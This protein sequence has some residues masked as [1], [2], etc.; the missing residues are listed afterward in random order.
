M[1]LVNNVLMLLL[2]VYFSV[3]ECA[4]ILT[5]IP[6]P[7]F[8]H[9]IATQPIW[10]EL[11]LRG[12]QVTSLTTDPVN[13][14]QL[15]NLTEI[16]IKFSNN[17][18]KLMY[19]NHFQTYIDLYDILAISCDAQLERPLIQDLIKSENES[20]DLVI[21]ETT[22]P[23][24]FAFAHKFNCPSIG[25]TTL[26][27]TPAIYSVLGNP[28]HPILYPDYWL[29]YSKD[30]SI[31]DRIFSV[32][33]YVFIMIH[34]KF[35]LMP[36]YQGIMERH[37]G[38]DY[39]PLQQL[40]ANMSVQLVNTD[41]IFRQIRPMTPGIIPIGGGLHRLPPEPLSNDL[42]R[43]LDN[44]NKGFIYFSLGSNVKSEF[45]H[46]ERRNE[47]LAAFAELPYTVI[48]KYGNNS[49]PN[50]PKNVLI[51]QW[52]PQISV[53]NHPNIKLF[54]THGGLQSVTEAIY[55]HVPMIGIPFFVD[56]FKNVQEMVDD[57]YG[58]H[59]GRE[60]LEKGYMQR[61]ILEAINN[62]K[63]RIKLKELTKLA[64]DQPMT[65]L[66]RAVWWIEYVLR[67]EGEIHLRSPTIDIPFYQHYFLDVIALLLVVFLGLLKVSLTILKLTLKFIF[68]SKRPK[69]FH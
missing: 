62:P 69:V 45:L 34:D 13:D 50:K 44:A 28:T 22:R 25:I 46:D 52:L 32:I 36:M 54:I 43:I 35:T 51:Y 4:R 5:I 53:L 11:S 41:P 65:G 68:Y 27:T 47:I 49:I 14:P 15:T 1:N 55:A 64:N 39:P 18:K 19:S 31:F 42:K 63:Y 61:T 26:D 17:I 10:K 58:L 38:K 8:S 30:R 6:T 23:V 24:Y 9:Q 66:E 37:F 2:L 21:T 33:H 3:Y 7:S 59:L 57:G 20:F 16:D 56:Q 29:S 67:H 48:W 40:I 12:H 60:N